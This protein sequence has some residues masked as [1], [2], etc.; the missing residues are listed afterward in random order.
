MELWKLS[1]QANA[2][3][4]EVLGLGNM[5]SVG[6]VGEGLSMLGGC[7]FSP[8]PEATQPVSQY[9]YSLL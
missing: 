4:K 5:D 7:P 9:D 1:P 8:L 2:L 3:W 6:S